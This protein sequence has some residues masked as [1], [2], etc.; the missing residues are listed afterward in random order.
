MDDEG[1]EESKGRKTKER[2]LRSAKSSK[3]DVVQHHIKKKERKKKGILS[4][5]AISP[6]PSPEVFSQRQTQT[7][8]GSDEVVRKNIQPSVSIENYHHHQK[9]SSPMAPVS[10]SNTNLEDVDVEVLRFNSPD[11]SAGYVMTTGTTHPGT[12]SLSPSSNSPSQTSPFIPPSPCNF[13]PSS[14]LPPNTFSSLPSPSFHHS[15]Q[16]LFS[17]SSSSSYTSIFTPQGMVGRSSSPS[18]PPSPPPPPAA[19]GGVTAKPL[20]LHQHVLAEGFLDFYQSEQ[21]SDVT[22]ICKKAGKS[23][24]AH[25][26][27]LASSS[28]YF[29]NLFIEN[30]EVSEIHLEVADPNNVFPDVIKY[31]YSGDVVI[32]SEN[33]I[34]LLALADKLDLSD[35]KTQ[36][37]RYLAGSIR[38][39]NCISMLKRAFEFDAKEVIDKCTNV[40]ARNFCFLHV[41]FSFLPP[42]IYL[43]I[44]Q[45]EDLA[46]KS[47]VDLL[48]DLQSYVH[49][50][51]NISE[52][53][54][55]KEILDEM[56]RCIRFVQFSMDQLRA[57]VIGNSMIPPDVIIE[58]LAA[59]VTTLEQNTSSS[60]SSLPPL[61][62]NPH[63]FKKRKQP[64]LT[65]G[66]SEKKGGVGPN[67]NGVLNWI[68]TNCGIT[69]WQNSSLQAIVKVTGFLN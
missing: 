17:S 1:N 68:A 34:P 10:R 25:R 18:P 53:P 31:I 37:S 19:G 2:K 43:K 14:P 45:H 67:G 8:L 35:L 26:L 50:R 7:N 47:E 41:D 60:S 59:K 66:Y 24:R 52:E 27:I 20:V 12:R 4:E 48:T 65:L 55:S 64:G 42:H 61:P 3:K 23:Y 11:P 39:E 13:L 63:L 51:K 22:L 40:I 54:I 32:N 46:V 38:H 21:F 58:S 15:P 28:Q 69:E 6:P 49:S 30:N 29:H 33:S 56:V 36:S 57:H 62:T 44:L 16:P 9:G 5:N